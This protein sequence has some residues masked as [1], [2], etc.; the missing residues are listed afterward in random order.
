VRDWDLVQSSI[1]GDPVFPAPFVEEAF[2]QNI[3]GL[4]SH[5]SNDHTHVGLSGSSILFY[6]SSCLFLSENHAVF[7]TM[8]L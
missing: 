5:K 3:F 4:L 7:I 8:A 2:F 1:G 6:W